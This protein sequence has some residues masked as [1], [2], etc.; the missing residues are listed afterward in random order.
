[1]AL[2]L[3][4]IFLLTMILTSGCAK[5]LNPMMMG[6]TLVHP[7]YK[8]PKILVSYRADGELSP[9]I[10]YYLVETEKGEAIFEEVKNGT[11]ALFTTHWRDDRGDHFTSWVAGGP[12]YEFIVPIDRSKPAHRYLYPVNQYKADR[13]KGVGVGAVVPKKSFEPK[14]TLTPE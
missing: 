12:G 14:N 9:D 11:S 6:G 10:K 1:M 4:G 13:K 7:E 5:M 2:S 8:P 3:Q